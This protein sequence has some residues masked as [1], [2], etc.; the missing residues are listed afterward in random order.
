MGIVAIIRDVAAPD[1]R[2]GDRIATE[3]DNPAYEVTAV[4]VSQ[5]SV[6]VADS[7]GAVHT[8]DESDR[9]DVIRAD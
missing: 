1:L 2:I 4:D 7:G 6:Q 8:Y 3:G 5:G 9:M